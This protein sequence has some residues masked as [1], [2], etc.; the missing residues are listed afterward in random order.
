[1]HNTNI[2]QYNCQA[3]LQ[4][5][6]K[7]LIRA[8]QTLQNTVNFILNIFIIFFLL[9]F[10][11]FGICKATFILSLSFIICYIFQTKSEKFMLILGYIF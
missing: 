9:I 4:S 3:R 10:L 11:V 2:I 5:L 6:I 7:I 8:T 1:M